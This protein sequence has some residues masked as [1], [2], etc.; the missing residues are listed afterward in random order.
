M[1]LITAWTAWNPGRL[2]FHS[3]AQAGDFRL[4][5]QRGG[6]HG[7]DSGELRLRPRADPEGRAGAWGGRIARRR[8]LEDAAAVGA[9]LGAPAVGLGVC[10]G[11]PPMPW[12]EASFPPAPSTGGDSFPANGFRPNWGLP[13]PAK[14]A[15]VERR[16]YGNVVVEAMACG[17]PVVPTAG[18]P[19][20]LCSRGSPDAGAPDGRRGHGRGRRGSEQLNRYELPPLGGAALLPGGVRGPDRG[21]VSEG[22]RFW[23]P[24]SVACP[25]PARRLQHPKLPRV[26]GGRPL[27]SASQ[28]AVLLNRS[29]DWYPCSSAARATGLRR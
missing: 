9:Q 12:V 19:A 22:C 24:I 14:H 8:V 13:V 16:A 3:A 26:A 25:S 21:L 28:R 18:R 4:G 23:A 5:R 15:Q 11:F 7:F 1:R 6:G 2:A 17:V 27:R 20:E 10:G 29:G